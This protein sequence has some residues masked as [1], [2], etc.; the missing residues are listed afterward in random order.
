[1]P[2]ISHSSLIFLSCAAILC[3][4]VQRLLRSRLQR[5]QY[6]YMRDLCLTAVLT[7]LALWSNSRTISVLVA[8]A[9]LALHIGLMEQTC[10]NRGWRWLMPLPGA[11]FAIMGARIS[12]F[13]LY[14]GGYLYLTF[15]QSM[16]L[17]TAWMTLFPML[18]QKLDQIPGLAGHLLSV[19]LS[20]MLFITSLSSQALSEAFLVAFA[21]LLLVG[22]FWSRLG[23]HY[24]QLGH[25]LAGL[26]GIIVAGISILG[27]SK[28]VAI[29]ALMVIPLGFYALPLMELSLGFMSHAFTSRQTSTVP[30]LYSKILERG[31]DH[32]AAVRLVTAICFLVGGAITFMQIGPDGVATKVL[33]LSLAAVLVL[34]VWSLWGGKAV[35]QT[36]RTLWGVKIDGISMNYALSRTLSWLKQ[37]T[38]RLHIITTVNAI[39]MHDSLGDPHYRRIINESDMTVADGTGLVWALR[40]LNI[41]VLERITGVDFLG[42]LCRLAA[43][44]EYPIFLYGGKPGIA[45]QAA[46]NLQKENPGLLIA[47]T[48][49]GYHSAEEQQGIAEA[50]SNSGAKILFVALGLPA[51]EK[52]IDAHKECLNGMVAVG[53]GGSFDVYAGVLKR[54]PRFWQKTG[55]EWLY[56]LIQ[57]P[58]RLKRDLTL[59]SFALKIAGEK[60][61]IKARRRE[62]THR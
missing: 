54:A 32:P 19:S 52:W 9:I 41:P 40:F 30:Y 39:A 62:D 56:R 3:V 6:F 22:A 45:A 42:R 23:H 4:I 34:L 53:V 12:F 36:N 57:E 51:Q 61:G 27:V 2:V 1:M 49:H 43:V 29:T 5:D 46:K 60:V 47:G 24:R 35:P 44:E 17:T 37:E 58:S 38:S 31:V 10:P 14:D 20:L 55:L 7:L 16:L 50:I 48:E 15:W 8:S 59:F 33:V 11:F 25:A 21:S 13:A 18:F 26:W 28:G